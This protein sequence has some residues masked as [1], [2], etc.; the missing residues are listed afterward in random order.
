MRN[1]WG[2]FFLAVPIF[3]GFTLSGMEIVKDS[4]PQAEII[5]GAKAH[6]AEK[7]AAEDLGFWIEEITGAKLPVLNAPSGTKKTCIYVGREFAEKIF[8]ADFRELNGTDGFAVR[9]KDGALYLFGPKPRSSVYA[10]S[11]L[12]ENNTDIIW[13]RPDA[14]YGHVFS[15]TKNLELKKT[16]YRDKPEFLLHGWNVVA[17]R[18]DEPTA[19]W[20]IRNRGNYADQAEPKGKE[21]TLGFMEKTGGHIYWWMAHPDRYFKTHPEYYGYS[22]ISGK[23]EPETLCLTAPGLIDVAVENLSKRIDAMR[24]PPE[25]LN[26]GFRDSWNMCQCEKCTAP[27]PLADGKVLEC[28]SLT[29]QEDCRY[30]STRYLLFAGEIARRLKKKY[31]DMLFSGSGYFYSAEPPA[32]DIPEFFL[33]GFC[34][35]GGVDSRYPILSANQNPVWKRRLTEWGSRFPGRVWFYEYY[36]SYFSGYAEITGIGSIRQKIG[37]DLRDLKEKIKGPGVISELT[38]DSDRKFSNHTMKSEWDANTIGAWLIARLMW[39]PYQDLA[40]LEEQFFSRT[41]REAAPAMKKFYELLY[42]AWSDPARKTDKGYSIFQAPYEKVC[43]E[44]LCEAEN[45]AQHP[46]SKIMIQRLKAQWLLA[47]SKAG[48]NT[49]PQ[50]S[51]E[52]KFMEPSATCYET[53]LVLDM[54]AVPGYFDWGKTVPPKYATELRLLSDGEKLYIRVDAKNPN[55]VFR[56]KAGD[57]APS[58]D[59]VQIVLQIGRGRHSFTLDGEGNFHTSKSYESKPV[60]AVAKNKSGYQAVLALPFASLGIDLKNTMTFPSI[61][62]IRRAYDGKTEEISTLSG[63]FPGLI[64]EKLSF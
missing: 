2:S 64:K 55:A 40:R 51:R 21:G 45:L 48:V 7:F 23:R 36:R 8:P 1:A 44:A 5:V 62:V 57:A 30:Y 59:L 50:M 61:A 37:Q 42:K 14:N 41:Y 16:D 39:N 10:V 4:V 54:F 52:E 20:V 24:V 17:I 56:K 15:K 6:S 32:C 27:I 31:P 9:E 13:A 22:K 38:P 18:R 43:F 47:K 3:F 29:P 33:I 60:L 11:S 34:P 28:K 53:S 19:K 12:L 25:Y 35:I 26:I 49:V 46:H 63:I 58:G